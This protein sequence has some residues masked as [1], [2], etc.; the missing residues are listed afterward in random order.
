MSSQSY[1]T[2]EDCALIR[3]FIQDDLEEIKVTLVGKDMR[4]GMV[5][6]IAWLKMQIK[7]LIKKKE[8]KIELSDKW[9]ITIY[10]SITGWV[11]TLISLILFLISLV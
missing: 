1:V 8:R 9:K 5:A 3:R 2:R 11:G 6:D 7:K 10:A 4:G